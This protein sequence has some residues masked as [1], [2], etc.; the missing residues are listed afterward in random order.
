[1]AERHTQDRSTQGIQ[2]NIVFDR[3]TNCWSMQTTAAPI[4]AGAADEMLSQKKQQF[5]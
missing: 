5:L 2:K 4:I 3:K 1:M